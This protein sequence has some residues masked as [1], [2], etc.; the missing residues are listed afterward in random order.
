M[1]TCKTCGHVFENS[2]GELMKSRIPRLVRGFSK[3]GVPTEEDE[4]IRCCYCPKKSATEKG[5]M[6]ELF[7]LG[8]DVNVVVTEGQPHYFH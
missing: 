7:G 3:D 6:R 8:S 2:M 5:L 1:K 4:I